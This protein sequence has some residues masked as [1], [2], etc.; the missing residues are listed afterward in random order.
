[1]L[2]SFFL[3]SPVPIPINESVYNLMISVKIATGVIMRK[4]RLTESQIVG[5]LNEAEA[6]M[7]VKK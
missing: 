3:I 6:G 2:L 7:K 5:I 1:M 4:S